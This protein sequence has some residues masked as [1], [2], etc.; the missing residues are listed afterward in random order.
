MMVI[1]EELGIILRTKEGREAFPER[2]EK[3]KRHLWKCIKRKKKNRHSDGN[4]LKY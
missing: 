3:E 1:I 4:H 2:L